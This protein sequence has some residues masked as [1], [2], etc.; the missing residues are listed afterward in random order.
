LP[1]DSAKCDSQSATASPIDGGEMLP[2]QVARFARSTRSSTSVPG[3][4]GTSARV[5]GVSSLVSGG[6]AAGVDTTSRPGDN[7]ARCDGRAARRARPWLS[8]RALDGS[9]VEFSSTRTSLD[10]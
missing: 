2:V 9:A 4:S 10:G 8:G 6:G 1:G 3:G 7:R 5:Q